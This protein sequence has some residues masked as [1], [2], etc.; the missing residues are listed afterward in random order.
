MSV[1]AGRTDSVKTPWRRCTT[2]NRRPEKLAKLK[3]GGPAGGTFENEIKLFDGEITPTRVMVNCTAVGPE[4]RLKYGAGAAVAPEPST[5]VPNKEGAYDS[6]LVSN[7]D[8]NERV[9]PPSSR[10]EALK[11]LTPPTFLSAGCS[12]GHSCP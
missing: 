6:L 8:S 3:I 1:E 4:Q 11:W 10:V 9:W 7:E 2:G 5:R 12:Q